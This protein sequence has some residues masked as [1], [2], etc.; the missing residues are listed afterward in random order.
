[1]TTYVLDASAGTDLLLATVGGRSILDQLQSGAQWWVPE[2]YFVEVASVLR[3][4]E[5][6]GLINS[7]KAASAFRLPAAAPLH[8]VQTRPLLEEAW[9]KRG[10]L[11][12]Y[13]ALYIVLAEHLHPTLVTSD[14]RLARSPQL[15]V[16]VI[17][18]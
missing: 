4:A 16:T 10:H 14:L 7:A 9:S 3:R 5:L 15:S 1:M 8:R 11:T 6:S 18:P 17:V 12:V 13:D 2:H